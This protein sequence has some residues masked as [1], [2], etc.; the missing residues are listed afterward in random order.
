MAVLPVLLV[1]VLY[2]YSSR[3]AWT[4]LL[5]YYARYGITGMAIAGCTKPVAWASDRVVHGAWSMV[6]GG[7]RSR[8]FSVVPST[9]SMLLGLERAIVVVSLSIVAIAILTIAIA[10]S[11]TCSS[12]WISIELQHA[13]DTIGTR[14]PGLIYLSTIQYSIHRTYY[15][16]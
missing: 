12:R 13:F 11:N 15:S 2:R 8:R 10:K 7:L 14:V 1:P 6:H 4:F 5:Q 9:C 16:I 3:G